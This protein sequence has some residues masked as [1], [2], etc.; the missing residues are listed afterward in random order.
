M[1]LSCKAIRHAHGNT[2]NNLVLLW[3]TSTA[4]SDAQSGPPQT[5]C[6]WVA[7][8]QSN[9]LLW[10]LEGHS[11]AIRGGACAADQPRIAT[12]SDDGTVRLWHPFSDTPQAS[13]APQRRS[14]AGASSPPKRR[15]S[16]GGS[17]MA[18]PGVRRFSLTGGATLGPSTKRLSTSGGALPS[19]RRITISGAGRPSTSGLDLPLSPTFP[20]AGQGAKRSKGRAVTTDGHESAVRCVAWAPDKH[21]LATAADDRR[22][23]LWDMRTGAESGSLD[24]HRGS[25]RAVAFGPEG[26]RMASASADGTVSGRKGGT[27]AVRRVHLDECICGHGLDP[28]SD[29][30]KQYRGR[31]RSLCSPK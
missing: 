28:V 15:S 12:A 30:Q 10:R 31:T 18:S 2:Q 20:A 7:E 1:G 17:A 3:D 4:H 11:R 5:A 29:I 6:I 19:S 14:N 21:R 9:K 24:G 8:P 27:E 13:A 25:V 16:S 23:L 26:V 22:I